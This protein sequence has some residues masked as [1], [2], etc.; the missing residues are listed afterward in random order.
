MPPS[1]IEKL[2]QV[3]DVAS[4]TRRMQSLGVLFDVMLQVATAIDLIM[5]VSQLRAWYWRQRDELVYGSITS[6]T[7]PVKLT[8]NRLNGEKRICICM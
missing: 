5:P 2:I 4:L 3:S 6:R 7:R 8:N 1:L